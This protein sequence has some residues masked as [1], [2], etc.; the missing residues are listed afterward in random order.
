MTA[1]VGTDAGPTAGA[2][3]RGSLDE[4]VAIDAP[5]NEFE[6]A[7]RQGRRVP[8]S[9]LLDRF[10]AAGGDP[11]RLSPELL[12]LEEELRGGGDRAGACERPAPSSPP[13]PARRVGDY[14]LLG[15]LARG[16]MGVVYRARQVSLGREVALKMIL[17]GEF[18]SEIELRRFRAE[19][20]ARPGRGATG[21]RAGYRDR[22][23]IPG[24]V[25]RPGRR[26]AARVG[27]S[28][29][30]RS[31]PRAGPHDGL[32]RDLTISQRRA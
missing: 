14:E 29:R 30:G 7:L 6:R 12:A 3:S 10:Q 16:G 19:A 11:S 22:P 28:G 2:S 27:A 20:A 17:S 26:A 25:G 21:R 1:R 4:A 23:D 9:E 32:R 31:T 8:A 18:A 13:V 15:E 24:P 5:C